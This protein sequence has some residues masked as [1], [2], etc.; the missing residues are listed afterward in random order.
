MRL[1]RFGVKIC[2]GLTFINQRDVVQNSNEVIE[3]IRL[4]YST[5]NDTAHAVHHQGAMYVST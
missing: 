1:C 5:V 2:N 4:S 3:S